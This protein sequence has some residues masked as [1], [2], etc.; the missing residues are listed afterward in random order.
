MITVPEVL[1]ELKSLGTEQTRKTFCNHGADPSKLFGVKVGD[2]KVVAKKIKNNQ[3]LAM[4]L[5]DS[6]IVD[7]QYLAGLV[8]DGSKMTKKQLDSWSKNAGWQMVSEYTVAWVASENPAGQELALKWIQS[9]SENIATS[10][11]ATLSAIVSTK[12][13]EELDL[14]VFEAL[15][16]QVVESIHQAP[17][18][19][20]S[21]MNGFVIALGSYV[22]PLNAKAKAAAKKIGNVEVDVGNTSCKVPD[23][24]S[25]IQK[26]EAAKRVGLKRKTAKC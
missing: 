3:Q 5:F 20:R 14:K 24:L 2:M 10:G 4:E 13:D 22:R 18:R 9:K 17:N 8:A 23:A 12:P 11:W 15:L 16:Q 21:T 26:I 1:A 25:Y 6:G 7:A 19:V